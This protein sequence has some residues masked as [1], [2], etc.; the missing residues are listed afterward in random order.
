M[1]FNTEIGQILVRN[2]NKMLRRLVDTRYTGQR[3]NPLVEIGGIP[4]LETRLRSQI[5]VVWPYIEK[6]KRQ[7]ETECVQ[8]EPRGT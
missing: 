8:Y 2:E 7:F 4:R 6:A 5:E 3:V 1:G